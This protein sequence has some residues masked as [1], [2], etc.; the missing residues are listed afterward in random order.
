MTT[1]TEMSHFGA[2]V[3]YPPTIQPAL[4]KNIPL[5]IKNTFNPSFPGTWISRKSDDAGHPVKGI[6][7][8]NQICLLTV[9][10]SGLFG[11]PGIAAR[12]FGALAQAGVNIVLITQGSSETSITFAV[13]PNQAD[14]AKQAVEKEFAYELRSGLVDTLKIESDLAVVA[15]VGENMRYPG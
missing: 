11:V 8:I 9:Q 15:V 7:S 10:G 3:I 13:S 5:V 2:K 1:D 12:L 6:S 14:A 4:A